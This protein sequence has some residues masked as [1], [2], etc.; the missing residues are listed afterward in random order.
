MTENPLANLGDLAKPATALIEKISDA[1]GGVFK[2]FQ[3]VRVARA[4]AEA[5][6]IRAEARIEISDLQRRAMYRFLAEEAK[7]QANIESITSKAFPLLGENSSPKDMEDDWITNFF[8]KSRIISDEDMQHLWSKVLAGE[9][10]SP[11]TFSK[12]TVNLLA[13][14]DKRDAQLFTRLCGFVWVI[15]NFTP[16]IFDLQN[17]IYTRAGLTF[18]S[19]THLDTIGLVKFDNVAGFLRLGLPKKA[20]V[21]YYCTPV[22]LTLPNE[23]DNQ[24]SIGRALFTQAGSELAPVCGSTPVEGFFDFACERW[25]NAKLIPNKDNVPNQEP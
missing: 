3:I 14:L 23:S 9:A 20:T 17:E 4:E 7:Q 2:P 6:L 16:L 22:E 1:V 19:M 15:G 21:F 10:N 25:A 11:G 24:L 8:D 13:D 18:D 12:R 5:E